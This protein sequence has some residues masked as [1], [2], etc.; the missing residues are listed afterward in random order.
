MR[1]QTWTPHPPPSPALPLFVSLALVAARCQV[2][3]SPITVQ[4]TGQG[5]EASGQQ[6]VCTWGLSAITQVSLNANPPP[7]SGL[8]LSRFSRVQLFATLWTVARQAPLSIGFSRQEYW[9]ELPF[10]SP[11]DLPNPG[12]EPVSLRPPALAWAGRFF[13]TS[14]IWEALR[15]LQFCEDSWFPETVGDNKH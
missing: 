2:T 11:G 10:P 14:A 9:S 4:V 8:V 3:D 5:T 12:I 6:P 13:T 15:W 7:W 1:S